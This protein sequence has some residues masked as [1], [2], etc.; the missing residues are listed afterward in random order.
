MLSRGPCTR[1]SKGDKQLMSGRSLK[2]VACVA[3]ALFLLTMA[4]ACSGGSRA[5]T[6]EAEPELHLTIDAPESPAVD[7]PFSVAGWGAD[8]SA[9]SG[10]GVE[11]VDVLDGGCDGALLGQA[12]YGLSRPDVARQDGEQFTDS[13]WEFV[14]DTLSAGEHRLAVRLQ[15]ALS[16]SSACQTVLVTIQP[17]PLLTIELPAEP[18]VL[19]P[20]RIGGWGI[21]LA[22]QLGSGIER[23]DILDGGCEGTLLGQARYGLTRGDLAERYGDQ[24]GKS[25][26][27]LDVKQLGVGEH[28]LGVRLY[29]AAGGVSVCQTLTVSVR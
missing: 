20:F 24:F 28:V 8:F 23:V 9:A 21:D 5:L 17:K 29:S 19:L 11:R 16:D 10:P 25:G 18:S 14:V 13:G 4:A 26:W 15:S 3:T 1:V 22:A 27:E 7:L 2:G 6:D 12:T